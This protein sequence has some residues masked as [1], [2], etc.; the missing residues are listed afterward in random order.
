MYTDIHMA[1]R[2]ADE[3][4]QKLR[5]DF[6]LTRY[7]GKYHV[8]EHGSGY[9]KHMVLEIFRSPAHYAFPKERR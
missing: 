1:I 4:A 9:N 3:M 2:D 8:L 5:K 7:D 6:V